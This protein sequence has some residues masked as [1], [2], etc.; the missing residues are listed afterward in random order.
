MRTPI[1]RATQIPITRQTV[2]ATTKDGLTVCFRLESP[3][4][5]PDGLFLFSHVP[6]TV[7]FALPASY[8]HNSRAQKQINILRDLG[9]HVRLTEIADAQPP[10]HDPVTRLIIAARSG[11]AFFYHLHRQVR[12][13]ATTIR[14]DIYHASGLYVLP[15][16][17]QVAQKQGGRLVY[18]AREL[19]PH[20]S[21]TI[22]RPWARSFWSAVERR[23]IRRADVVFT[24]SDGIADHLAQQYRITKPTVVYNAPDTT[25]EIVPR[26]IRTLAGIPPDKPIVLHL[27]AIRRDRG[28]DTL[29]EAVAGVPE[30]HLVFLG[31]ID[32]RSA[33]QTI[34]DA[35]NIGSRVH[36]LPPCP[37][38]EVLQWAASADIGVSLLRD[39][40]LNHRLALPNKLFEYLAAGLPVLTSALP[41]MKHV[42]ATYDVGRT[43]DQVDAKTVMATLKAMIDDVDGRRRWSANSGKVFETFGWQHASQVFA[44]AYRKILEDPTLDS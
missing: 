43:I 32:G 17:A 27:G 30:A 11:P 14:A 3:S 31:G 38:E 18:D 12:R 36:F 6:K 26:D 4:G 7:L 23:F 44:R 21:G 16:M 10:L 37:T 13:A 22:R 35:L 41:E 19:Y 34:V 33:L 2:T 9:L 28:C 40:C 39:S 24:V 42:V 1:T 15:A 25:K 5:S 8:R 20:V 29:A